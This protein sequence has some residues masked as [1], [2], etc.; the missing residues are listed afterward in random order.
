MKLR[1]GIRPFIF[2]AILVLVSGLIG[3]SH[4]NLHAQAQRVKYQSGNNYLIVEALDDDLIHFELSAQGPG[5][6]IN[7]PLYTTPMVYK[8]NYAG[9]STFS[10]NGGTIET[11]DIKVEVNTSSLC[12]TIT[13]KTKNVVLSTQC[14]LN[15][16][17]TWKGLTLTPEGMQ[18]VYGL[19]EQFI[20]T[21]A[22]DGDW[23]GRQ[24]TP[25]NNYG[26]AMTGYNGGATGNAQFPVMYA[27]GA[28]NTN[29]ALFLDQV[30]KQA[31]NFQ[32]TPWRVETWGD[33]I[34]WYVMTGPN[35]P[36]LRQD[37]LELTGRPPVPPIKAFGLWVSEY[38]YDNWSELDSKLTSLRNN[39]FPIDGFVL[40]LQ[41]FGGITA[42]SDNTQM[43]SLTWDTSNFP[44]PSG[45]IAALEHDEGVGI[46]VIEES[47]IGKGLAEHQ[48]LENRGYL[49]RNCNGCSPVYL[50][51]NSWWGK[52]GYMDWTNDAAG[53][54]WH[55]TKRQALINDGVIGHWTDLGEPE[56]F[57]SSAWYNGL[58]G[59]NKHEHADVHNIY[60]FKWSESI[61]DGYQRHNVTQRPF[62]V[63]RSGTSGSQRLGVS[64]WSGDIGSNLSSLATHQNTQMHMSMSGVDYYGADI[65]G[66]HRG[67]L[68]GDLNEMYTRWFA[69]GAAFDVPIRPHTE[70]LCNCK[71][72]APDQIGHMDSN[73]DNLRQRYELTPYYYS[74]AHRAYLY[75]E[76]VVPPL[77]FYYQND[78]NVREM[79]NQ[80]LIGRSL[81]VG[82]VTSYNQTQRDIYLPSGTW[83]DYFTNQWH[84]SSGQTINNVPVYRNNLFKL[85]M[86]VHAGA[87]I[88]KMHVDD[89]TM[90]LMGKRT[91]SS[92]RDELIIAVYADAAASSFTL[93]EDDGQSIAYQSGAVRTTELSQQLSGTSATVTIAAAS[94][95]Y[96]GANASRNNVVE[97]VVND[98]AATAVT[99]NGTGLTPH[100]SQASFDAASSGW[101][102]AGNNLIL[103]KSG[104]AAVASAKTFVFTL[105]NGP[106]PT[107][108][109]GGPTHTPA[110]TTTPGGTV[111]MNFVCYNGTTQWGESVYV[112]G[113]MAQ[114]GNWNANSGIKLDPNNYP[115]WDGVISNLPPNTSFEWKCIK[116]LESGGNATQW[117]NGSNNSATTLNAGQ[118]NT[119]GD[120][121]GGSGP[122]LT[123]TSGP[124]ST[125][126]TAATATPPP[127]A[128]P[129][130]GSQ[131]VSMEFVCNN[132]HTQW[133][134]S[135]Y[136]VGNISQLGNWNSNNAVKLDP[137]NYPTWR[138][139]I[140]NL[141]PNTTIEWKCI[142]RWESGGNANQWEPGANNI[143]T[144]PAS[145]HGGITT[146][147]F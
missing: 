18:N 26:N 136:V 79:G 104:N 66:F 54:Y 121:N 84:Q 43:G 83:I 80:K 23:V 114:L 138:G 40:D 86:F 22:A 36:D 47:Y 11:A 21:N 51:G 82:I 4:Q 97:L 50:T 81:L 30:Y 143:F 78:G 125:P 68:D 94:G 90:N 75:G 115:T 98:A 106:A 24:R 96:T 2:W 141:P 88:P 92:T 44:N 3:T 87:I 93:Y 71:Q 123:P 109:P 110:P 72:T 85:P 119:T 13:D 10:Q 35:L 77:V 46:M 17:N 19:G 37:Y 135:V 76:P 28:N 32:G 120:F 41:W 58:P 111:S 8:T 67:G 116:R 14:P 126:T 127:T 59:L 108:T 133:G 45:K 38:G 70:N 16:A 112:V 31:W 53:D 60:N 48:D 62:M 137:H 131:P 95:T 49:V 25:G 56:M 91:D 101:F 74:L 63:S 99:L 57:D 140:T 89:N 29:Y 132:G 64:M 65:G 7:D 103:A 139:T 52:G 15:L 20:G 130:P 61:F 124:T 12:V 134:E 122:T 6:G 105:T 129:T 1:L 117:Q 102:N 145:G 34:R 9:P 39:S 118:G 5:P 128:T 147:D 113:N 27:V 69:N 73:R 100:G 55:D 142:K 107:A 144:S 33:Q 146:G 42:G